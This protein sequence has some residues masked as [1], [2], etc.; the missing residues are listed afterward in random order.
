[1]GVD[2][3][4]DPVDSGVLS[5]GLVGGVDEDDFEVLEGGILTN[6]VGIEDS[7]A[8]NS[9]ANS[10]FS[11]ISQ[12]SGELKLDNTLVD[13][14]SVDYTLGD[15]FLSATSSDSDSV[16]DV[17]LLLFV[18]QSSSFIRS[19]RLS[20]SM[21]GGE[22]S[23]FIGSHSENEAHDIGLLS[24]PELFEIFVCTHYL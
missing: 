18:S 6:P 22:L 9:S 1:M 14:L 5:D 10:F 19:R 12:V 4:A 23:E 8:T 7:E 2:G 17:A 3:I 15:G 21:D 24:L 20:A 13:G 11:D 16:D